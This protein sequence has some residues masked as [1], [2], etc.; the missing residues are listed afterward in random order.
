MLL[1]TISDNTTTIYADNTADA[2]LGAFAPSAAYASRA[3]LVKV[4]RPEGVEY[5]GH[6][7]GGEYTV[8]LHMVSN[9]DGSV[10]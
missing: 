9:N 8:F 4:M 2:S 5:T 1:T 10:I 6:V 7:E 3:H